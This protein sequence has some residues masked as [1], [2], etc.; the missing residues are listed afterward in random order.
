MS[1][2][3]TI[4]VQALVALSLSAPAMAMDDLASVFAGCTG[5][6]SAE[7]EH[8]WLMNSDR[9]DDLEGLRLQF[10]TLLDAITPPEQA[11]QVLHFRIEAK[12]AHAAMLTTA[13]FGTDPRLVHMAQNQAALRVRDCRNLLLDS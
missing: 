2:K 8:A 10:V 9:A 4:A 3:R 12:L 6:I 1:R 11:R 7:M 13:T 5:R